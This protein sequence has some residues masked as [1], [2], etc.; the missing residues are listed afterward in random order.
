MSQDSEC[1]IVIL[2]GG[3]TK[4]FAAFRSGSLLKGFSSDIMTFSFPP[5]SRTSLL[6]TCQVSALLFKNVICKVNFL[7]EL[8]VIP[9]Y[10][11]RAMFSKVA[12]L[13]LNLRLTLSRSY[14][15]RPDRWPRFDL[16]FLC[17]PCRLVQLLTRWVLPWVQYIGNL[18]WNLTVRRMEETSCLISDDMR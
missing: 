8:L 5:K 6:C 9:P 10:W 11:C 12:L 2:K 14:V 1:I 3:L 18:R 13:F 7:S 17:A 4:I 15:S 16:L